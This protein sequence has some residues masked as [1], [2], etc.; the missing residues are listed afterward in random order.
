ML[1]K[2][3]SCINLN[4][5]EFGFL[6]LSYLLFLF[7]R[8]IKEKV[9]LLMF[10]TYFESP[11]EHILNKNLDQLDKQLFKNDTKNQLNSTMSTIFSDN[12]NVHAQ[13]RYLL[14]SV[15]EKKE[16]LEEDVVSLHR[17]NNESYFSE[18][19]KISTIKQKYNM[20]SR[21][22]DMNSNKINRNTHC[23]SRNKGRASESLCS[24]F[25][26]NY[27]AYIWEIGDEFSELHFI[28]YI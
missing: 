2:I 11:G 20:S 25:I 4:N 12:G 23:T 22:R 9:T 27:P 17:G 7:L 10:Y 19:D 8:H 16:L 26:E 24:H 1:T 21:I 3:F 15:P 5:K 18:N 28:F 13:E 14:S 6:H